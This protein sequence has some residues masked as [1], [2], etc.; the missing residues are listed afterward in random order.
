MTIDISR[1]SE[2]PVKKDLQLKVSIL[3]KGKTLVDVIENVNDEILDLGRER[4]FFLSN[5]LEKVAAKAVD[6]A[7][8]DY[9][10]T[11]K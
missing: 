4:H 1:E 11:N 7:L 10:A 6:Q 8:K 9:D 5:K 2:K 3:H